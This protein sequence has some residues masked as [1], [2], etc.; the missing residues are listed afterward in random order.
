MTGSLLA[1]RLKTEVRD[2]I[3][4]AAGETFAEAGFA[5]ASLGDVVARAG[6]SVGNLYKYFA[7]KGALFDAF[8]PPTFPRELTARIAAQVRALR[9]EPD[10]TR[11]PPGHPYHR[12]SEALL[13]FTLA[14]RHRV[15]F[16]LLRAEGTAHAPFADALVRQLVA[17]STAYARVAY[18]RFAR[19]PASRRTLTRLYRSFVATLGAVLAEERGDGA[20]R[21]AL[22]ATR[23][24]HLAGLAALFAGAPLDPPAPR[25]RAATPRR[26]AAP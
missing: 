10:V 6:T 7:G 24:Y 3:L 12:A 16:L 8:L 22:A 1:Q 19:A 25:K 2:A 26:G 18:P 11:L 9:A 4:R 17:L 14:H 15:V 20:V 5:G 21:A 23:T 13:G